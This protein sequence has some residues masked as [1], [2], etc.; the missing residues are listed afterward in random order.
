MSHPEQQA[1]FSAV[2]TANRALVRGSSVLEIGSYDVNGSIRD[3]FTDCSEYVGV[4][5]VPGSGVDRVAYGHQVDDADERYDIT[6]S[7][8]CFEHNPYWRETLS[9]MVRMTRP[10]GLVAFTCA[11]RCRLEHGT[12]RTTAFDSPG[13]QAEGLDYYRNLTEAD[14]RVLPLGNWFTRWKFWY[15]PTSFDLYFAGIRTGQTT[16]CVAALP[17]DTEVKAIRRI[18]SAKLRTLKLPLRVLRT[19]APDEE[20]YQKSALL[21]WRT[22]DTML[23]PYHALRRA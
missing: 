17:N 11:S 9:N 4:D 14:F 7:G 22:V 23:K 5:L 2:A 12:T 19:V 10:G 21:Y 6:L 8:E 18:C 20:T 13:T 16:G 15:M 1:F 3:M